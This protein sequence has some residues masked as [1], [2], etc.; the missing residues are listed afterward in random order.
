MVVIVNLTCCSINF[1]EYGSDGLIST[2]VDVYSYGILLMEVFTRRRPTDEMFSGE[3]T[4]RR[5]VLGSFPSSVM[6]IVDQ[7]LLKMSDERH[8]RC[9]TSGMELAL[10]CTAD[11]AGERPKMKDVVER[12]KMIKLDL[13]KSKS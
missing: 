13:F 10:E 3:L 5:W 11:F 6:Q 12:M 8:E 2:M 4:M 1:V 7:Q 9:L